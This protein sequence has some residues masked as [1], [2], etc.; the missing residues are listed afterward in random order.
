MI[1]WLD[2]VVVSWMSYVRSRTFMVV[3]CYIMWVIIVFRSGYIYSQRRTLRYIWLTWEYNVWVWDTKKNNV[4]S[5]IY[6]NFYHIFFSTFIPS[7]PPTSL[8]THSCYINFL[9]YCYRDNS[10][11]YRKYPSIYWY[12]TDSI[13]KTYFKLEFS[14]TSLW[15]FHLSFF[16]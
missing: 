8:Y 1:K 4:F 11:V 13:S 6:Y 2:S 14:I 9:V 3:H 12:I 7:I 16:R 15:K 5:L 10:I